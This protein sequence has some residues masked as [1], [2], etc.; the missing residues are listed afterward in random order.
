MRPVLSREAVK[1]EQ[2]LLIF[3]QAFA[4]F[5][6]LGSLTENELVVTCQSRFANRRQVH[7]MD[8][9]LG[10]APNA[11]GHFSQ[12]VDRLMNPTAFLATWPYSSCK[13]IQ[14]PREP[15]PI[16]SFGAV[17]SPRRLS[18]PSSSRQDWVLSL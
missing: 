12:D 1:G 13:A 18:A 8:Q 2:E 14:K 3:F 5:G 15:S 4:G 6:E 17:E 9:L 7:F 16:A 10:L 11:L